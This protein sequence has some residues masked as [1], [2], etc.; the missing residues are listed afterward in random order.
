[1]NYITKNKTSLIIF[2]IIFLSLIHWYTTRVEI[3]RI[4]TDTKAFLTSVE[5]TKQD[6]SYIDCFF[7]Y[8]DI[9]GRENTIELCK[10]LAY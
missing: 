10:E 5:L 8:Q 3:Q 2:G 7:T 9:Y 1:M 4:K 6:E